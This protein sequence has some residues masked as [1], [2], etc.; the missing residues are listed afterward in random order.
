MNPAPGCM[1]DAIAG[2]VTT[3]M[4]R[5][6]TQHHTLHEAQR[7]WRRVAGPALAAHSRPVNFRRGVLYV[8]AADSGT[9]YALSLEKPALLKKLSG[10]GAQPVQDIV[11]R[12]GR[13][14]G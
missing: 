13:A 1:P 3:I 4:T 5:A 7:R 14:R 8:E 11:I 9:A 12:A 6:A 2:L 10:M